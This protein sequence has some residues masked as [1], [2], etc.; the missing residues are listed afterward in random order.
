MSE[1]REAGCRGDL[2]D[3]F[4]AGRPRDREPEFHQEQVWEVKGSQ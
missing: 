3:A 1:C 4:R 2:E